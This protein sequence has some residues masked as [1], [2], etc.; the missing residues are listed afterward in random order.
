[1]NEMNF[2]WFHFLSRCI[3]HCK[4]YFP[5]TL[6]THPVSARDTG[7]RL[8]NQPPFQREQS[9]AKSGDEKDIKTY[10]NRKMVKGVH[11]VENNKLIKEITIPVFLTRLSCRKKKSLKWSKLSDKSNKNSIYGW[12][13]QLFRITRD[14]GLN[15]LCWHN[16]ENNTM[17]HNTPFIMVQNTFRARSWAGRYFRSHF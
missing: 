1:M 10:S 17:V 8:I 6:S 11:N 16:F 9:K 2:I 3:V 5:R 12:C 13:L 4:W 14:L 7:T 15:K